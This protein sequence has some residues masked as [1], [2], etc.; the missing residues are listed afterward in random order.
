M[1]QACLK[2]CA[3]P[4]CPEK[5]PSGYC[6]EHARAKDR[7]RGNF[8]ERGYDARWDRRSRRFLRKYP[9][10]GMRPGGLQPV[11]SRCFDEERTTA[12]YQTDHVVPHRGDQR[13]FDDEQGNWQALCREC[14]A[15]KSRAGL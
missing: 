15:R 10:C 14:G 9:L 6:A 13:L 7:E 5:V 12:A 3:W 1:P 2:Y 11:M 8:R 4:S